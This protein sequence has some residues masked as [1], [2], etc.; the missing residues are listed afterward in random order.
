MGQQYHAHSADDFS[1]GQLV[2]VRNEN[3][4]FNKLNCVE[5][6][7]RHYIFVHSFPPD[8]RDMH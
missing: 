1:V 4:L 2:L 6:F 7:M 8:E 5:V 3:Q